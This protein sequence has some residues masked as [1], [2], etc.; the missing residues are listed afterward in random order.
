MDLIFAEHCSGIERNLL[1]VDVKKF[2]FN[3]YEITDVRK[4]KNIS[5]TLRQL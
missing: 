5:R 3:H 1:Q 2:Y 4:W